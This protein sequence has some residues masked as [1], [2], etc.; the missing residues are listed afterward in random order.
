MKNSTYQIEYTV[1]TQSEGYTLKII[2]EE[3]TN[4]IFPE[5]I[6]HLSEREIRH[7]TEN[8]TYYHKSIRNHVRA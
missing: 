2:M 3:R 5:F 1:N 6:V 4:D 7:V 8:F